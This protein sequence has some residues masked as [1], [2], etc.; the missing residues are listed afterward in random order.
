MSLSKKRI[1]DK[2]EIVG[3]FKH[4]QVRYQDQIIENG[5]VISDSYYR[6]TINC[7]DIEKAK[8]HN[9]DNIANVIWNEEIK[10]SYVDYINSLEPTKE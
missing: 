2:I 6:D 3:E 8:E 7:G 9:V 1:Q 4:I 10:K 5:N